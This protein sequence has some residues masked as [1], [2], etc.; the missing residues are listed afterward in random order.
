[1]TFDRFLPDYGILPSAYF[2][3]SAITNPMEIFWSDELL[4]LSRLCGAKEEWI[5]ERA[6]DYDRF[7]SL[8]RALPLLEGHPTRAW[9][10]SVLEHYFNLKE[11][12]TEETAPD[13]WRTLCKKLLENPISQKDLVS[14]AWLC[15]ALSIPNSLPENITPVLNANLLL[16]TNTQN[17]AAWSFEIA[18]TV[19]HFAVNGCQKVVLKLQ[20]GFEFISPSIYHVNRALTLPKKDRGAANVL[21]CQLMRE[22]CIA[23]QKHDLLLI[24]IC[25]ENPTAA[26]RLLQYVKESVGLPRL[27]WSVREAREAHALLNFTA[28]EHNTDILA[29]LSYDGVMTTSELSAAVESWQMRYPV[30]RLCFLTA[31]D[32]RQTP[33]AQAHIAN[34][35]KK[36]KTKI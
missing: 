14:G 17:T 22:L 9:I 13:A 27:C 8:C 16:E 3:K 1:M 2:E 7:F 6:S 32:L 33:F 23:A 28:Q 24:L 29:A 26:S 36:P 4:A 25:D 18:E 12:P 34:M 35:L 5:G 19:S 11:V 10:I 30:A 31:R 15:D 21:T 20:N